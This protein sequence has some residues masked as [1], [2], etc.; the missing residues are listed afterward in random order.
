MIRD[1]L[2]DL[3]WITVAASSLVAFGIGLAWYAPRSLGNLWA[4]QVTRYTGI[5]QAEIDAA[6]GRPPA[7]G[8]WL[9]TIA[10][11]AIVLALAIDLGGVDSAWDGAL[12]GLVLGIGLGA[13]LSSWPLIFARMPGT[14]WMLNIGAFLVM[15]VAMGSIVGA[16]R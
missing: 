14:W 15:Q 7:L 12:L 5:P 11:N 10:I 13:T 16:W 4:R 2:G 9:A 6:A 1:A 8:A 3:N